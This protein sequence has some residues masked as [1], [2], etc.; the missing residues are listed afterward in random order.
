MS[1]TREIMAFFTC[2]RCLLVF[3]NSFTGYIMKVE[4]EDFFPTKSDPLDPET[5]YGPPLDPETPYGPDPED[6]VC[7]ELGSVDLTCNCGKC[8]CKTNVVGDTC[9]QCEIE[10]YDFPNCKGRYSFSEFK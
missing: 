7:N 5:P 9:D 6:C 2:I 1:D 8:L 3:A 4:K 10:H